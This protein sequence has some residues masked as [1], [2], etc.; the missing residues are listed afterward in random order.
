MEQNGKANMQIICAAK[1]KLL[2][3]AFGVIKN[4]RPFDPN[5]AQFA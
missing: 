4:N 1:R 2:H 5:M 3:I